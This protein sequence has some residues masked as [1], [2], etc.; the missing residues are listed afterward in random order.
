MYKK[1]IKIAKAFFTKLQEKRLIKIFFSILRFRANDK[2]SCMA[3]AEQFFMCLRQVGAKPEG[4]PGVKHLNKRQKMTIQFSC[5]RDTN[6][7]LFCLH[8]APENVCVSYGTVGWRTLNERTFLT[9]HDEK[10]NWKS[11]FRAIDLCLPCLKVWRILLIQIWSFSDI[12]FLN[13]FTL[14]L[15][16]FHLTSNSWKNVFVLEICCFIL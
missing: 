13:R 1:I 9:Q 10:K 15:P 6:C 12:F 4:K 14:C 2:S 8:F 5:P 11:I 7:F 3:P 16:T